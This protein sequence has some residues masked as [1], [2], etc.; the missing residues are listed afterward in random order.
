MFIYIYNIA[1]LKLGLSHIP[2]HNFKSKMRT[3]LSIDENVLSKNNSIVQKCFS[4][5]NIH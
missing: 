2:F 3:Y 4:L 1:P 5:V